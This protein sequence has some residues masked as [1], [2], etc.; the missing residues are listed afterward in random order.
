MIIIGI[1]ITITVIGVIS[2]FVFFNNHL[3]KSIDITNKGGYYY[4]K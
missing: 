4:L 1:L 2:Y 3:N